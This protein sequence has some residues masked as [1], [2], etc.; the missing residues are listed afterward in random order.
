MI[1]TTGISRSGKSSTIG[2]F[3]FGRNFRH[4]KGSELLRKAGRPIRQISKATANENQRILLELLKAL[5][6][7]DMTIFDGHVLIET[8][9]GIFPVPDWVFDGLMMS[10]MICI[11][12]DP[13]EI[14]ASRGQQAWNVEVKDI[15]QLQEAERRYAISQAKRLTV[16]CF[17]VRAFDIAGFS[18]A[19]ESHI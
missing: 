11:I 12:N 8:T 5:P 6:I 15:E 19:I 14:V 4:L 10:K 1:F 16:P 2:Q 9:E 17:E 13:E 7:D 3:I 18:A